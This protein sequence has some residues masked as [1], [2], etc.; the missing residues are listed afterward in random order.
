MDKIQQLQNELDMERRNYTKYQQEKN[1]LESE[2]RNL[3]QKLSTLNKQYSTSNGKIRKIEKKLDEQQDLKSLLELMEK[4]AIKS[5]GK[6]QVFYVV[7]NSQFS[8]SLKKYL[9][10]NFH[11]PTLLKDT[12]Y[13]LAYEYLL[14]YK[15]GLPKSTKTH[16]Y[17]AKSIFHDIDYFR[18]YISVP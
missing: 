16:Y 5:N 4:E 13:D 3:Q 12:N 9:N 17:K 15:N 11:P 8:N 18:K 1:E 2:I 14:F 10:K 6:T 7:G